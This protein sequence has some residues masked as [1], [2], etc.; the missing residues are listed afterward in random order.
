MSGRATGRHHLDTVNRR[1]C[2]AEANVSGERCHG[3]KDLRGTRAIRDVRLGRTVEGQPW[4][5]RK[6]G[7]VL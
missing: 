6:R 5:R 1:T 7:T 4:S 2:R 3:G